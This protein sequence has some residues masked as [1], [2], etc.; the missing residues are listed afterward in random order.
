MAL[1][2]LTTEAQ[3]RRGLTEAKKSCLGLRCS[4]IVSVPLCLCGERQSKLTIKKTSK[5]P[6][7]HPQ[8]NSKEPVIC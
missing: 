7:I 3:R 2:Y 8:K 6:H 5:A 4:K 1:C